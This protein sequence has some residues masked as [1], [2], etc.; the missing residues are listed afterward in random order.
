M[1]PVALRI[2]QH[3][4]A[5]A[6]TKELGEDSHLLG[7]HAATGRETAAKHAP[8]R[9]VLLFWTRLSESQLLPLFRNAA[10]WPHHL[11]QLSFPNSQYS[12]VLSSSLPSPSVFAIRRSPLHHSFHR[13]GS[14]APRFTLFAMVWSFKLWVNPTTRVPDRFKWVGI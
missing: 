7:L 13:G 3:V 6:A 4:V 9:P 1:P 5:I 10:G 11:L 14:F 2:F 8:Q 12:L